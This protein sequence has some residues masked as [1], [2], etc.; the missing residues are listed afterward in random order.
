M[1]RA[2]SILS[3]ALAVLLAV[4]ATTAVAR[5]ETARSRGLAA[6]R[7]GRGRGL[8][9]WRLRLTIRDYGALV[10]GAPVRSHRCRLY[11]GPLD[12]GP[13]RS[14]LRIADLEPGDPPNVV[15]SLFTEHAHCCALE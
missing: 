12:T 15:L 2:P 13:H 5:T 4:C 14:A 7:M 10:Y 11:C 8:H 6:T 3:A 1:R 9:P